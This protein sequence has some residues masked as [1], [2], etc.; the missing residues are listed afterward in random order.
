[1]GQKIKPNKFVHTF[2]FIEHL[3]EHICRFATQPAKNESDFN[4]QS[5]QMTGVV[6]E[7]RAC[8]EDSIEVSVRLA[9]EQEG[10][11]NTE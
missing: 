9:E 8:T 5:A 4:I 2:R 1:V 3:V 11:E 7:L 6:T 10:R